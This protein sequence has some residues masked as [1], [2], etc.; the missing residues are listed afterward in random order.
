MNMVPDRPMKKTQEADIL[1]RLRARNPTAG[2]QP[3]VI[4]LLDS[5]EHTSANGIHQVLLTETVLPLLTDFNNGYSKFEPRVT[6]DHLRPTIEGLTY[7]HSHGIAHGGNFCPGRVTTPAASD[8][9]QRLLPVRILDFGSAYIMDG[10]APPFYAAPEITF[11][12]VALNTNDP[13]W[14]QRSDIWS[15]GV[16][17]H[18]LVGVRGLFPELYHNTMG[19]PHYMVCICGEIPD[20]W[21]DHIESKPWPLGFDPGMTEEFWD[22][23][24]TSF[25]KLG[26]EDLARLVR[27]M[28]RMLVLD[29]AK[30]PSAQELLEDPY[31]CP[32]LKV[33]YPWFAFGSI[34]PH[35]ALPTNNPLDPAERLSA[36]ELLD[37]PYS[38]S[39]SGA[40]IAFGTIDPHMQLPTGIP[41]ARAADRRTNHISGAAGARAVR[42][43]SK[44]YS[45]TLL[46]G[47]EFRSLPVPANAFDERCKK[48]L[49]GTKYTLKASCVQKYSESPPGMTQILQKAI[50]D[51]RRLG[52]CGKRSRTI[53]RRL[54][55]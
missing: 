14:D 6:K 2:Q 22:S 35:M 11:P 20:A 19:L 23:R 32:P 48:C 26:V 46:G 27:L 38:S 50:S 55:N 18:N 10:S 17:F 3:N 47:L 28:R 43:P 31:F 49:N 39:S 33:V 7:I 36:Q 13:P 16:T 54:R 5:F 34:D 42:M 24:K 15:L 4:K 45:E 25:A 41:P 40:G 1:E 12:R 29:P 30:R 53:K 52:E 37:D 8:V 9:L 51:A 44:V 21:R